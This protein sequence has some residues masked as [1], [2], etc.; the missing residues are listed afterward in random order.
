MPNFGNKITGKVGKIFATDVTESN[1]K[2]YMRRKLW[3]DLTKIDQYTGQRGFENWCEIEFNGEGCAMLDTFKTGDIV[4]VQIEVMGRP[5]RYPAD[6]PRRPNEAAVFNTIRGRSIEYRTAQAIAPQS[7][8]TP[9]PMQ[10]A[11]APQPTRK[12]SHEQQVDFMAQT[13]AAMPTPAPA[14]PSEEESDLPF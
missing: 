13:V 3:L 14:P 4:N 12:M 6:H 2:T 5:Y 10:T 9:P 8:T 1:G 11:T 7:T